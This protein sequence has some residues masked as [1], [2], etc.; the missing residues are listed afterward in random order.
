MNSKFNKIDL[1]SISSFKIDITSRR[2]FHS[3]MTL[4]SSDEDDLIKR[5]QNLKIDS[6]TISTATATATDGEHT[7]IDSDTDIK[8]KPEQIEKLKQNL[9]DLINLRKEEES[10][11]EV[12]ASNLD[13]SSSSFEES[14]PNY[15]K[16]ES[17]SDIDYSVFDIFSQMSKKIENEQ[18]NKILSESGIIEGL[19][20]ICKDPLI[21]TTIEFNS[22][23]NCIKKL[24]R[25]M[26]NLS[27][28][29]ENLKSK[30]E[31][32]DNRVSKIEYLD[33]N[34]GIE[35]FNT[36]LEI[37]LKNQDNINVIVNAGAIIS[38]M[39]VARLLIKTYTKAVYYENLPANIPP[40]DI[41]QMQKMRMR[42]VRLF[43]LTVVPMVVGSM[44]FL[45]RNTSLFS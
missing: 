44:I 37:F 7:N 23:D 45:S 18:L 42:E 14:F 34:K 12:S 5:I 8:L 31:E 28:N 13:L 4:N 3:T 30:L 39:L 21:M 29:S 17:E 38:P 32:L 10:P 26:L 16:S 25:I 43:S 6:P 22:L 1:I 36:S 2:G 41:I 20:F 33:I 11:L 24:D 40:K 35:N 27:N 19:K 9:E 15:N